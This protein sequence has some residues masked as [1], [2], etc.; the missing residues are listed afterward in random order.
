ME[1]RGT[2][3]LAS[4]LDNQTFTFRTQLE[5]V[6][7]GEVEAIH[8][9]RVATRRIRELLALV[10]VVP[11]RAR[12]DDAAKAYKKVGRVLGRVRDID[13][14]LAL[15]QNLEAH[16]TQTAP[17]LVIIRQDYE[18]ERLSKTRRLIKTLERIDV[19]ALLHAAS[20]GHPGGLRR[21][22]MSNGWQRQLSRLVI[23]RA[24]D[25]VTAIAHATGVYF[26]KRAHSTRIAIKQV[27]YAAQIADATGIGDIQPAIKT[28][29]KGQEILGD[30][31]DRQTLADTVER[32]ADHDGVK[33][34]QIEL[35][36]EVLEREVIQLHREYLAR[37]A[38]LRDACAEIER[39]ASRT[40]RDHRPLVAMSTALAMSG[41]V[42]AQYALAAGS[43][44]S[45]REVRTATSNAASTFPPIPRSQ[46]IVVS[47]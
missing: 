24:R 40:W 31:H 20:E 28:L 35:T 17:S 41:I 39:S 26:P 10:P 4:L 5:S 33:A 2:R 21:R 11:G 45:R 43:R 9:A 30:L 36:H 14:Q 47:G 16:A 19:G 46:S 29:R 23:E 1:M 25:A 3:T 27:R 15:I 37:R 7:E 22:L 18:R 34:A 44:E 6:Y 32:Y 12:E 13:V 42:A 38:A 8:D